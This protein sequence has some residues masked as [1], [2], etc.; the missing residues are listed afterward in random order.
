MPSPSPNAGLL[1]RP[2]A[3]SCLSNNSDD[4]N[5]TTQVP[6]SV[7]L[8]TPSPADGSPL[9]IAWNCVSSPQSLLP[10]CLATTGRPTCPQWMKK[11]QTYLIW[12]YPWEYFNHPLSLAEL[13]HLQACTVN[14]MYCLNGRL[15]P[16]GTLTHI[17]NMVFVLTILYEPIGFEGNDNWLRLQ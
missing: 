5:P 12:P 2:V 10:T 8:S 6:D 4:H 13:I 15:A 9:Q 11:I 7:I 14:V 17:I 3:S 1:I 16:C